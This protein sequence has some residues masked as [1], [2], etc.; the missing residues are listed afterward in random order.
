MY[1]RGPG[2]APPTWDPPL[3]S[4]AAP[5]TRAAVCCGD[6]RGAHL[7]GPLWHHDLPRFWASR[8]RQVCSACQK[9][10]RTGRAPSARHSLA[11][12]MT[13]ARRSP[14]RGRSLSTVP[15][16]VTRVAQVASLKVGICKVIIYGMR[17]QSW[18][19][20]HEHFD[21]ILSASM[22]ASILH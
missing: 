10:T 7:R 11:R 5:V 17:A 13:H 15:A 18:K 8:G 12:P 3:L 2:C 4:R 22:W 19:V 20:S 21:G 6:R 9:G 14:Q 16:R 1:W